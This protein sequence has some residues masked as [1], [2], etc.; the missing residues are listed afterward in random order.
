MKQYNDD[1]GDQ[2]CFQELP[3]VWQLN[4]ISYLFSGTVGLSFTLALNTG[5]LVSTT[6]FFLQTFST[7][8]AKSFSFLQLGVGEGL[9]GVGFFG[10]RFKNVNLGN[11]DLILWWIF[12]QHRAK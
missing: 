2:F 7:K 11:F 8:L 1:E 3:W 12:E 6:L 4:T 9:D 5:I 10:V